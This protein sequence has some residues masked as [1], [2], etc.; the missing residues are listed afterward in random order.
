MLI[1]KLVNVVTVAQH[2]MSR[3]A[4]RPK[5]VHRL[6]ARLCLPY[7]HFSANACACAS[8]WQRRSVRRYNVQAPVFFSWK[9]L[10]GGS[11]AGSTAPGRQVES[12]NNTA[13][14]DCG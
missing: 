3:R 9:D 7:L 5:F 14:R 1:S 2:G 10:E 11:Q 4:F 8:E 6:F 12:G 13:E